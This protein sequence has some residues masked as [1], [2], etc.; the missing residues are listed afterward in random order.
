M[1][2]LESIFL[3]LVQG[4]AEFLPVS[5][6]GHLVILQT[7]MG[8]TKGNVVFDVF[9]HL[10]TL[11]AVVWVYRADLGRIFAGK[12]VGE[13]DS[14][15][16]TR[17]LLLF[18]LL[19]VL[20]TGVVLPFKDRL[21]TLFENVDGVRIFLLV[22]A[23]AL[24]TLPALRKTGR[25]LGSLTW[26]G[27]IVIGLCQAVGALPG[28]SR[29]GSTILAGLLLGLR[30]RDACRYSFLL[31]IPTILIA[32]IVQIP[33]AIEARSLFAFG[34]WALGFLI[35][36]AAGIVAIPFLIGIVEKG[37]LWG[38]A[39]YCALVGIALFFVTPPQANL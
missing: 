5:S 23:A 27:A 37:K 9:L 31:S 28:I 29:S 16:P 10:A 21:E 17:R 24:A 38:F 4:F 34:P 33:D 15:I 12:M 8:L 39:V 7:F 19:S 20:A 26:I 18:I 13:G 22:N 32:A 1:T 36:L 6:S 14:G 3:G 2:Y 30:P 25:D 11:V 35:A